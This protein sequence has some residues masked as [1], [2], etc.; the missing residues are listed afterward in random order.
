MGRGTIGATQCVFTGLR[1][2]GNTYCVAPIVGGEFHP[3]SVQFWAVG[4]NCCGLR[5]NF[6]CGPVQEPGRAGLVLHDYSKETPD[7]WGRG[8][9]KS[10]CASGGAVKVLVRL[11][12]SSCAVARVYWGV[13]GGD[14]PSVLSCGVGRLFFVDYPDLRGPATWAGGGW[15]FLGLE[16]ICSSQTQL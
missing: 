7:L 8:G 5:D 14:C 12:R 9:G 15:E 10:S 13:G 4:A 16:F 11:L 3:P 2:A 1:A 6:Q